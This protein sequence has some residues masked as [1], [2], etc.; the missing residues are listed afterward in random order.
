ME[1]IIRINNYSFEKPLTSDNSGFS[2]WGFGTRGGKT[3]FVKEFLSPTYP[4][5]DKVYTEEKKK[6]KIVLCTKYVEQKKKIY[7]ALRKVTDGNLVVV[8]QFFR[9]GAKYYIS[10][11]AITGSPLSITDIASYPFIDRLQLCCSVAHAMARVHEKNIVHA[12]IKPDNILVIPTRLNGLKPNII[13][14]DCSFFENESPKLGEELNGDMVYLSPEVFLHLAGIE[15]NLTTQIDVFALGLLFY[16]YL[17]GTLPVFDKTK[18][19][20]A[21]EAILDGKE[22]GLNAV[23][24]ETCQA[25]I[26]KMLNIDPKNRPQIRSVFNTLNGLL[27]ELSGRIKPNKLDSIK[28]ESQSK[29]KNS[30]FEI[31]G[32]LEL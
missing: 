20:Y 10:T 11:Q 30:Y 25:L 5:D 31:A 26:Q 2:K 6:S 19:Q 7:E 12:D 4:A 24:N 17:T 16:Q 14:F 9:V 13:D 15:S 8:E 3:Y 18:Y 21:Y 32:D 23:K 1:E 22:L 27:L 28:T 29:N